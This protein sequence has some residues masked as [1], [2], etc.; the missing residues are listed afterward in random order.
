MKMNTD[1]MPVIVSKPVCLLL[2]G[3]LAKDREAAGYVQFYYHNAY[4][5]GKELY[6]KHM[7]MFI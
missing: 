1:K 4:V 7:Y 3:K 2:A 5:H 6:N